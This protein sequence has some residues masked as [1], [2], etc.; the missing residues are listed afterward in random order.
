MVGATPK[1]PRSSKRA[2][3]CPAPFAEERIR[4]EEGDLA[5]LVGQGVVHP[6]LQAASVEATARCFRGSERRRGSAWTGLLPRRSC[7]ACGSGTLPAD[8]SKEQVLWRPIQRIGPLG[9]TE[10]SD[11]QT[12]SE[13]GNT[14]YDSCHLGR[15]GIAAPGEEPILA[16]QQLGSVGSARP[17]SAR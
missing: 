1:S 8:P 9:W 6:S 3:T 5:R 4:V 7:T 13:C 15:F 14:M 12:A 17:R 2:V 10:P 16:I 11:R